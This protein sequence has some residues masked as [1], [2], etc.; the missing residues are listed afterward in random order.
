MSWVASLLLQLYKTPTQSF[1]QLVSHYLEDHTSL[2]SALSVSAWAFIHQFLAKIYIGTSSSHGSQCSPCGVQ[3]HQQSL[4]ESFEN[5]GEML[6]QTKYSVHKLMMP[7]GSKASATLAA[8]VSL[9][10]T[11]S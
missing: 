11:A 6:P 10:P 1:D 7:G 9:F 5:S 3:L 8:G 4:L 2:S